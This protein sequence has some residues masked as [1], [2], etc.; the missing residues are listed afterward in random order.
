VGI[1][2]LVWIVAFGG[3][4]FFSWLVLVAALVCLW[5]Y[6]R[7][8]FPARRSGQLLGILAGL[9]AAAGVLKERPS[10]WIAGV[11]VLLFSS[12]LFSG[13]KLEERFDRLGWTLV[14]TLYL[15][16][17]LPHA[18]LVYRRPDG[19]E[20]IF[21]TLIVVMAGDTAAYFTGRAFG[22]RK[23]YPEVSPGKTVEGALG[24]TAASL[25]AGAAAGLYFLPARPWPELVAVALVLS[26]LGQVGDLFESWIK[27][28]FGVKDSGAILPGHGGLLDRMDS[29]I[30]PLVFVVYYVRLFPR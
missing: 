22:R 16:F 3:P 10:A 9:A 13:G 1:P 6:Y 18:A 30:F 4:R 28:V 12:C 27:R 17:L 26:V 23:L 7:M 20:W 15:G 11:A 2:A 14:G 24:G 19:P 25:A 21:F 8:V 29:L 5:E